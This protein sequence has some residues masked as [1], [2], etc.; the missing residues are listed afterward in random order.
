MGACLFVSLPTY[1]LLISLQLHFYKGPTASSVQSRGCSGRCIVISTESM[2][3][4]KRGERRTMHRVLAN[5][6]FMQLCT[7][8]CSP[9]FS[10]TT[11][12]YF[13]NY[14]WQ[15]RTFHPPA[16]FWPA[17]HQHLKTKRIKLHQKPH[18]TTSPQN[19]HCISDYI[20]THHTN[21]TKF[22]CLII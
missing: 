13:C 22:Y 17:S 2:H 9:P 21:L 18:Q 8:P 5:P 12:P 1:L 7:A 20:K 19:T 14:A 11:I 15:A 4:R 6:L 10:R 16:N 3:R